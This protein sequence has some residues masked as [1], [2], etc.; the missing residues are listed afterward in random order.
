MLQ[1]SINLGLS[2]SDF[3]EM[4]VAEVERYLDG[5]LWRMRTKAQYD[6]SLAN[7]IGVSIA[8]VISKDVS[9][10]AIEEV[11][12][13][14]FERKEEEKPIEQ[15]LTQKSVNNFLAAAMAIN[16]ARKESGGEQQE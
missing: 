12:S 3:W 16:K 2:E 1:P 11:Y 7:L 13:N 5:A 6:Y 8:R 10:P 14:L 4:T 9:F 15:D